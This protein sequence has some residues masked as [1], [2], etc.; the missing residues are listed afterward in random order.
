MG[1]DDAGGGEDELGDAGAVAFADDD[2]LEG[3]VAFADDVT[4]EL[5]AC[6]RNLDDAAVDMFAE[7]EFD[8][9]EAEGVADGGD[10]DDTGASLAM[11]PAKIPF[12]T[13]AEQRMKCHVTKKSGNIYITKSL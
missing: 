4:F 6:K 2:A 11:L 3:D 8:G 13:V 12:M 7:D 10:G 1:G 9:G 5:F